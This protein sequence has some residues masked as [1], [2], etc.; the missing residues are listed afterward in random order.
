MIPVTANEYIALGEDLCS[1]SVVVAINE[2]GVELN[3]KGIGMA[4]SLRKLRQHCEK[5]EL[6]VSCAQID[7][8]LAAALPSPSNAG[9]RSMI[10]L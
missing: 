3:V 5:L 4:N 9:K 7:M 2:K 1:L 6:P 8:A 10:R